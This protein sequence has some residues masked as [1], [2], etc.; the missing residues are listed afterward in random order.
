MVKVRGLKKK[1]RAKYAPKKMKSTRKKMFKKLGTTLGRKKRYMKKQKYKKKG[2]SKFK[3]KTDFKKSNKYMTKGLSKGLRLKKVSNYKSKKVFSKAKSLSSNIFKVKVD[4]QLNANEG[5]IFYNGSTFNSA[6]IFN[7]VFNVGEDKLL[8]MYRRQLYINV[9][10]RQ[11]D[12]NYVPD[13]LKDISFKML[14]TKVV[15]DNFTTKG[16]VGVL[17]FYK[18]YYICHQTTQ[19]FKFLFSQEEINNAFWLDICSRSTY[20]YS[21]TVNGVLDAI[22]TRFGTFAH[23]RA[24]NNNVTLANVVQ[25]VKSQCGLALATAIACYSKLKNNCMPSLIIH[26]TSSN[27][28]G[29]PSVLTYRIASCYR[30]YPMVVSAASTGL[31][32]RKFLNMLA[33]QANDD[34][35]WIN[36]AGD[37]ASLTT[38]VEGNG[39]TDNSHLILKQFKFMFQGLTDGQKTDTIAFFADILSTVN[40]TA[41]HTAIPIYLLE[42][43]TRARNVDRVY[44][45]TLEELIKQGIVGLKSLRDS[46][47]ISYKP[48][49]IGN[50]HYVANFGYPANITVHQVS[51]MNLVP[52]VSYLSLI[53]SNQELVSKF[54]PQF[55]EFIKRY[56]KPLLP[57]Y[58]FV[59]TEV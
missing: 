43:L 12:N 37:L 41:R 18:P 26:I 8:A 10:T 13:G 57:I 28:N 42:Y 59:M 14:D 51:S 44:F 52:H 31:L 46:N 7:A 20:L 11:A 4:Y 34:V 49:L 58:P 55:F 40:T 38:L 47:Q 27:V 21:E 23:I 22:G 50:L 25:Q 6:D 5:F 19:A 9:F 30:D 39:I 3:K 15:V 29:G 33:L 32:I 24:V 45:R 36:R 1:Y 2:F 56:L 54:T 53:R 17:S 16:N 48:Q 35:Q